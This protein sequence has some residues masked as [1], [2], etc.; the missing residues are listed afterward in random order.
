MPKVTYLLGAGASANALPIVKHIPDRILNQIEILEKPE[1][2]LSE[3]YCEFMQIK[4]DCSLKQG[5]ANLIQTLKWLY[6]EREKHSS[7]DTLAKKLT[8]TR[9]TNELEKLKSAVS[10]FFIT[11]QLLKQVDPRYDDFWA[12]LISSRN[13]LPENVNIL[14]WNYDYQLEMAYMPYFGG[15]GIRDVME[16][17]N[18]YSKFGNHRERKGFKVFKLNGTTGFRFK[19]QEYFLIPKSPESNGVDIQFVKNQVE[20]YE[21]AK[22]NSV[23]HMLSYAWENEYTDNGIIERAQEGTADTDILVLIGYSVPFFNREIDRKLIG[24]MKNLSKVYVQS[25]EAEN[26]RQRFRSVVEDKR[27]ISFELLT[28]KDKFFLP[29]EL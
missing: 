26:I 18:V 19:G 4:L 25:P 9:K 14:S 23:N 13:E 28:D 6:E 3:Q 2:Q 29:P 11:E 17:L 27:P 22:M 16:A 1:F 7:I 8:I 12:S 24:N 5:Q 10:I 15:T 20:F 21:G